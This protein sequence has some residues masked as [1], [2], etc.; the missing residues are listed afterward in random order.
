MWGE[1]GSWVVEVVYPIGL[2]T[3][4]FL[5]P[6]LFLRWR[7]RCAQ[8]SAVRRLEDIFAEVRVTR[9]EWS[10]AKRLIR[11]SNPTFF[12]YG[13]ARHLDQRCVL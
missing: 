12:L 1:I 9:E 5:F 10:E 6:W 2:T 11:E 3:M 8:R 4:L 13:T 7:H